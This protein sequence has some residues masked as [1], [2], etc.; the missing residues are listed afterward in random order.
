MIKRTIRE[1]KQIH[2]AYLLM[3]ISCPFPP[4]IRNG[5]IHKSIEQNVEAILLRGKAGGDPAGLNKHQKGLFLG[6]G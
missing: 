2:S 3:T 4:Q 6:R 5:M 1:M